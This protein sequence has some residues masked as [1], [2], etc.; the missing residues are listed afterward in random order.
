[1][2]RFS[3][4]LL[5]LVMIYNIAGYYM[6]VKVMRSQLKKQVTMIRLNMQAFPELKIVKESKKSL[7]SGKSNL[8]FVQ[9]NEFKLY[10]EMYDIISMVEQEDGIWFYCVKDKQEDKLLACL[11]QL[12]DETATSKNGK[13]ILK[14]L[15]KDYIP[16]DIQELNFIETLI[17][18]DYFV[19]TFADFLPGYIQ[20]PANPPEVIS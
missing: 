4:F 11:Q 19:S 9:T 20:L 10:G 8:V 15:L 12:I 17:Q 3:A 6:I 1:M 2:K 13:Q 5:L 16:L 7:S 18:Q 14:S